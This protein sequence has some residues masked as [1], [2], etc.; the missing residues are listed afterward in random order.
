M[1]RIG[2]K[3]KEARNNQ[4]LTIKQLA[5]KVG[6]SEK[7]IQEVEYGTKIINQDILDKIIKCLDTPISDSVIFE[8]YDES[9]EEKEVFKQKKIKPISKKVEVENQEQV[10]D[11]WNDAL[12]GI[13]AN[14]PV[15]DYKLDKPLSTKQMPITS[16]KIE[17]YPKDKVVY[18]KIMDNDMSGFRINRD[19]VAFSILSHDLDNNS[20]CLVEYQGERM[21]RQIQ[22]LDTHKILLISNPSNVRTETVS[23]KEINILARLLK[24]EF[25]I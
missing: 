18:I 10:Q 22:K 11:V 5:K 4:G 6:V 3:I 16:K 25:T 13:L 8:N 15:F 17:G 12:G 2:D 7:Y 9:Q 21:I 23:L 14:V 24:I 19:D 1:S 20:I